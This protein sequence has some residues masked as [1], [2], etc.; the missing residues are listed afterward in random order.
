MA[1]TNVRRE[2]RACEEAHHVLDFLV[3]ERQREDS[4]ETIYCGDLEMLTTW[5]WLLGFNPDM[6]Q[7]IAMLLPS[8]CLWALAWRVN[9]AFPASDVVTAATREWNRRRET[10]ELLTGEDMFTQMQR[11]IAGYHAEREREAVYRI[12]VARCLL[13]VATS[14]L[15]RALN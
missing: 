3:E 12:S 4:C 6:C 10:G 2:Q 13:S 1:M 8:Q 9:T 14:T 11:I 5:R 15:A 7:P